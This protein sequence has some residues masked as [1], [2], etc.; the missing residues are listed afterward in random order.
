MC[1]AKE[2]EPMDT[3]A[4]MRRAL[5]EALLARLDEERW[6]AE[7]LASEIRGLERTILALGGDPTPQSPG[8]KRRVGGL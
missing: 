8:E 5:L 4:E 7:L 2:I 3:H 1:M 6:S